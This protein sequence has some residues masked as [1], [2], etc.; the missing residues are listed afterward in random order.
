MFVLVCL[1][2]LP[3]FIKGKVFMMK[4]WINKSNS[5]R[6]SLSRKLARKKSF[7]CCCKYV[8]LIAFIF[9]KMWKV[10]ATLL[11]SFFFFWFFRWIKLSKTWSKKIKIVNIENHRILTWSG[12][13][14]KRLVWSSMTQMVPETPGVPGIGLNLFLAQ[15][16][17]RLLMWGSNRR[18]YFNTSRVTHRQLKALRQV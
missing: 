14:Q 1:F 8:E 6:L 17:V 9:G 4:V 12:T 18:S 3:R 10:F 5:Q 16:L 15:M 13:T 2:P 7:F 11:S